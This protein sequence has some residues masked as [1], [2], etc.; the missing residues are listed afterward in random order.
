ML[1]ENYIVGE[2]GLNMRD[3]ADEIYDLMLIQEEEHEDYIQELLKRGRNEK[4]E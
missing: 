1:S 4:E 3:L 2:G